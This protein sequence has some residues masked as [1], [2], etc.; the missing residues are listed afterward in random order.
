MTNITDVSPSF[1]YPLIL[2]IE[3]H[4]R[5]VKQRVMAEGFRDVFGGKPANLKPSLEIK[6]NKLLLSFP[7]YLLT[8]PIDANEELL[9]S[10]EQLKYKIIIKV[11]SNCERLCLELSAI[12]HSLLF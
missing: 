7:D 4:C 11:S 9:P 12:N 3:N 1:R 8:S 5:R 2:S 6:T 10:P